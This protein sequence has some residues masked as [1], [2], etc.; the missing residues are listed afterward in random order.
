MRAFLLAFRFLTIIP[1]G[2]GLE[3][4][5]ELIGASG[6]FYPLVGLILGGLFWCFYHGARFLFP[7]IMDTGLLLL[8]WVLL[9]GALHLDG[10]ADCL[11]SLYGGRDPESRL[12]IMKD[13]HLG[14]MGT[15]GL[16]LI[17]GLKFLALGVILPLQESTWWIILIP[18]LSRWTPIFLSCFHPYARPG[19][20]LGA[21]LVQG[22]GKKELFWAS[23]F[24]W[25]PVVLLERFW[26]VGVILVLLVWAF[27][28]GRYFF[29]K[30]GGITGDV[31]GAVIESSE[32]LAM[33][34]IIGVDPYV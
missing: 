22:T 24:A 21:A 4:S 13:V 7:P 17:S 18:A 10:L 16:I 14:T 8:F 23:L 27:F 31:M 12:R 33:L 32:L 19:G 28:C 6:K 3:F 9:T 34:V 30:I 2:K 1:L 15:V 25:A 11:D 5:P 20:G 29:N 26:G